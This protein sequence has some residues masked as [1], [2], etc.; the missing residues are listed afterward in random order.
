MGV[1]EGGK[2]ANAPPF[3]EILWGPCRLSKGVL[4]YFEKIGYRVV[5]QSRW[6]KQSIKRALSHLYNIHLLIVRP[7]SEM[8]WAH[9]NIIPNFDCV[10]GM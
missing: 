2:G 3:T 5:L 9:G 7:K 8:K 6:R 10:L 4:L 1:G